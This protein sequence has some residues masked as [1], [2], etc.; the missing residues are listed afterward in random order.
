MAPPKNAAVLV[1]DLDRLPADFDLSLWHRRPPANHALRRL[2]IHGDTSAE[3]IL[4]ELFELQAT[5]VVFLGLLVPEAVLA[6]RWA[7]LRV[8]LVLDEAE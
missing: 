8:V 5:A 1:G 7:G 3:A 4:R 6:A 2:S